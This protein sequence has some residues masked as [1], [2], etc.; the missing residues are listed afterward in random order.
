M[1]DDYASKQTEKVYLYSLKLSKNTGANFV[2]VQNMDDYQISDENDVTIIKGKFREL[3]NSSMNFFE[4]TSNWKTLA[5]NLTTTNIDT[6]VTEN[7]LVKIVKTNNDANLSDV[8]D[9]DD[10]RVDYNFKEPTQ[11]VLRLNNN[12]LQIRL[13]NDFVKD[14]TDKFYLYSLKLPKATNATLIASMSDYQISD[15]NNSSVIKGTFLALFN[16]NMTFLEIN[17]EWKTICNGLTVLD[18]DRP[19]NDEFLAKIVKTNIDPNLVQVTDISDE[20]IHYD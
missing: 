6:P 9:V 1:S 4:I 16:S 10:E 2:G 8:E 13:T 20:K 12:D 11:V 5:S 19:D 18:I 15:E 3:F 7:M 14:E 17:N